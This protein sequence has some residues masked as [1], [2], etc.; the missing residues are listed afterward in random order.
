MQ[1]EEQTK[2]DKIIFKCKH[3]ENDDIRY[4]QFYSL[5]KQSPQYANHIYRQNFDYETMPKVPIGIHIRCAKCSKD[6]FIIPNSYQGTMWGFDIPQQCIVNIVYEKP[7]FSAKKYIINSDGCLDI[8]VQTIDNE[9]ISVLNQETIIDSQNITEITKEKYQTLSSL[10]LPTVA[11]KS[12]NNILDNKTQGGNK[13]ES[14]NS[15]TNA[16]RKRQSKSINEQME[17][18]ESRAEAKRANES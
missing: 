3:C 10:G 6:T 5:N 13:H 15:S 11:T 14:T 8:V 4:M 7:K 2:E 18:D 12:T 1:I 16:F 9:T 17:C